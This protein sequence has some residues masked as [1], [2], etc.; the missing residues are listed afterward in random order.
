M[1][2]ARQ[3]PGTGFSR[4]GDA[5]P[6]T[7]PLGRANV[8]ARPGCATSGNTG[9]PPCERTAR[10]PSHFH[11]DSASTRRR[12]ATDFVTIGYVNLPDETTTRVPLLFNY[13]GEVI[14]AFALQAFLTWARIPM[15]EV[16]IE[17][18]SHIALPGGRKIPI[19]WDGTLMVNPNC[20]ETRTSFHVE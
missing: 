19:N 10:R 11:W 9:L 4:S 15:S 7:A 6:E 18:G 1:A 8:D 20:V 3:E 2:R 14:P 5:R 17:V 12:F 16:Q 13:R